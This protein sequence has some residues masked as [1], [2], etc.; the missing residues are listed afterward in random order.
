MS[1]ISIVIPVYYNEESLPALYQELLL[2]EKSLLEK[3]VGIELIFV[4]DGSGDNSFQELL[5]IKQQRP[6]TRIIKLTRNFGAVHASK[7]GFQFVTGDCF[8]T[9][10]ADL[11]DP[12]DLILQ[13]VE[14]WQAGAKY[15]VAA[16]TDRDDPLGS[17]FFSFIYYRLLRRFVIRDY[18][19]GGYDMALMDKQMLPYLQNSSK[20]MFTP[21]LAYWLGF[22][23][24]VLPYKRRKRLYGRSRWNFS[25]KLTTAIDA[26]F[27]FSFVP[28]RFIS[29]LGLL[30]SFASFG[31]GTWILINALLGRTDVAGFATVV[32]LI[33]FMQGLGIFMLGVIGEYVWRIFDEVNHRPETVIEAIY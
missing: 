4:D 33:A 19:D 18:P 15:V 5:K 22:Q 16:R 29:M 28:I 31:Y 9:L 14:R 1:K 8:L 23:P 27:G 32:T 30:V 3:G 24:V 21:L 17:K 12:P 25:Q 11:Q 10:A 2:L 20:N 26:L 6:D 7:T 13:M